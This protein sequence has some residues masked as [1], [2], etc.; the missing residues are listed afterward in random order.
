MVINLLAAGL[1]CLANANIF[2]YHLADASDDCSNFTDRVGA[3]DFKAFATR[4]AVAEVLATSPHDGR[5]FDE[6]RR[7]T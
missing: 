7:H 1:R 6:R 4:I 5:I 3:G 2:I